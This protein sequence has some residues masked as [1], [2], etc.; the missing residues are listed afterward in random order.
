MTVE[1][2]ADETT[3]RQGHDG[4][5]GPA[6]A[7]E[8]DVLTCEHCAFHAAFHAILAQS[9]ERRGDDGERQ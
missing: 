6:S 4:C 5:H 9:A 8:R 1:A 2:V 7:D 3:C